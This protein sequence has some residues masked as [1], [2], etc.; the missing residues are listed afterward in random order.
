MQAE[1]RTSLKTKLTF[2]AALL[3]LLGP[4]SS[5][6]SG[7]ARVGFNKD[8]IDERISESLHEV[9]RQILGAFFLALVLGW[10]GALLIATLITRPLEKLRQG[11]L[12]IGE[13]HLD[14]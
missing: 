10:V 3:V 9:D 1:K 13:G 4:D 5:S 6:F 14:H 7:V 8:V 12:L 2:F 11:A